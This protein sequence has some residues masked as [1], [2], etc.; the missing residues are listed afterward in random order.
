MLN[1]DRSAWEN[2]G[3]EEQFSRIDSKRREGTSI[4]LHAKDMDWEIARICATGLAESLTVRYYGGSAAALEK[5]VESLHD[6]QAKG[7]S[8]QRRRPR[9]Q[10]IS[11][12]AAAA[13]KS[14][15]LFGKN[16]AAALWPA[17]AAAHLDHHQLSLD[18]RGV[19][20][21]LSDVR[22]LERSIKLSSSRSVVRPENKA[23]WENRMLQVRACLSA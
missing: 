22:E 18:Y 1:P 7:I 2:R 19:K 3:D 11:V 17:H 4:H 8:L 12:A 15:P 20:T 16:V 9:L 21:A 5:V 23:V 14:V 10:F 13:L 6:Q